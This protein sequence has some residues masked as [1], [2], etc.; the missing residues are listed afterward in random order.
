VDTDGA[1]AGVTY[2]LYRQGLSRLDAGN[3]GAAAEVLEL[4][5]ER[6]PEKASLQ[7]ALGRAYFAAARVTAARDAFERALALDPTDDYAHFGIGRCFEREAKLSAAAKFYRLAC[8]LA[9]RGDYR[10]A[11]ARVERRLSS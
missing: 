2:T 6:A 11:L 1:D 3:P 5:V 8:A 7:E 9:P 4:A 10:N